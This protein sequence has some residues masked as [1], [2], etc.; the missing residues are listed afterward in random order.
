M[1]TGV[2]ASDRAQTTADRCLRLGA[3]PAL[4]LL[5]LGP[6]ELLEVVLVAHLPRGTTYKWV[7][8]SDAAR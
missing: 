3:S 8:D 7:H 5:P 4:E 6:H 2:A 1:D